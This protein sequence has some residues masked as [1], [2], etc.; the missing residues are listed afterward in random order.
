MGDGTTTEAGTVDATADPMDA[1]R[2]VMRAMWSGVAPSWDAY[3]D[4][5]EARGREVSAA[6]LAATGTGAGMQV[7]ELACGAGGLGIDVA[8]RV[9]PTGGVLLTDVADAMV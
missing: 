1:F 3:A 4:D 2:E 5:V 9:G 8:R 7:L 6:M